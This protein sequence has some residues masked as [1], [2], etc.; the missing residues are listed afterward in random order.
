MLSFGGTLYNVFFAPSSNI[1]PAEPHQCKID[2]VVALHELGSFTFLWQRV[3]QQGDWPSKVVRENLKLRTLLTILLS[4]ADY[5]RLKH[6][7]CLNPFQLRLY[8]L[9]DIIFDVVSSRV[10]S[11]LMPTA[12]GPFKKSSIITL[13]TLRCN[14]H[15]IVQ[16]RHVV[17]Y[18][19]AERMYRQ[20]TTSR[21][22]VLPDGE[23]DIS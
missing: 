1:S 21:R 16:R 18:W 8:A 12:A 9:L 17:A 23:I 19:S 10:A 4:P 13:C 3:Q 15:H 11:G 2:A 5:V 14:S 20:V 6:F 22:S 7:P